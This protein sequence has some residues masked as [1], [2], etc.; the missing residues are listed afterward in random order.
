M[1]YQTFSLLPNHQEGNLTHKNFVWK[2]TNRQLQLFAREHDANM[3]NMKTKQTQR[4]KFSCKIAIHPEWP[5]S[6]SYFIS[7]RFKRWKSLL[8]FIC[9]FLQ[10]YP[11][12]IL[13]SSCSWRISWR[14][15]KHCKNKSLTIHGPQAGSAVPHNE[16]VA[17]TWQSPN[18][19]CWYHISKQQHEACI[20]WIQLQN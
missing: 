8:P 18:A 19:H 9:V 17:L 13:T 11:G 4:F 14:S 5:V 3:L 2:G 7:C 16:Q 15:C 20:L 6:Q 10:K 12:L 1:T